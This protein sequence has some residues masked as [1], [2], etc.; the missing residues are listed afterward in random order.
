VERGEAAIASAGRDQ[1]CRPAAPRR[2]RCFHK[3]DL[4]SDWLDGLTSA[5]VPAELARF[6]DYVRDD[7]DD[8]ESLGPQNA[9]QLAAR[10]DALTQDDLE[11]T[12]ATAQMPGL[13][14]LV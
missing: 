9:G 2:G 10:Y 14:Y 4:D 1:A 6:I 7:R 8:D 11:E 3:N 12:V 13:K 5:T